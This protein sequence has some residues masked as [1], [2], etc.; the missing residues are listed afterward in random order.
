MRNQLRQFLTEIL[1][2]VLG[3][4][5]TEESDGRMTDSFLFHG[6]RLLVSDQTVCGS[7][8]NPY[9]TRVIPTI[10][11]RLTAARPLYRMYIIVHKHQPRQGTQ[12]KI[13]TQAR[14]KHTYIFRC[15]TVHTCTPLTHRSAGLAV[16]CQI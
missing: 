7:T 10:T 11:A 1:M 8:S 15:I 12:K 9:I 2:S 14:C 4:G 3:G 5:K 13:D 16:I 6:C